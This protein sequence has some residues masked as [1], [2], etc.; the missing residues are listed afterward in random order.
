[1]L[2]A[3]LSSSYAIIIIISKVVNT[4]RHFQTALRGKVRDKWERL[5]IIS[6]NQLIVAIITCD[7]DDT[8]M[9][10]GGPVVPSSIELLWLYHSSNWHTHRTTQEVVWEMLCSSICKPSTRGWGTSKCQVNVNTFKRLQS[11]LEVVHVRTN[12][13]DHNSVLPKTQHAFIS[14][15]MSL[16][17]VH[18]IH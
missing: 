13:Y 12:R 11:Y 16:L 3:H 7:M 9:K 6:G 14:H 10:D 2:K 17:V 18:V 15:A 5:I 1:V 8:N 4:Y